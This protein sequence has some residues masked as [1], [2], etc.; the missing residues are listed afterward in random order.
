[1]TE[2]LDFDNPRI[3]A[4]DLFLVDKYGNPGEGSPYLERSEVGPLLA[5]SLALNQGASAEVRIW[6]VQKDPWQFYSASGGLLFTVEN[7]RLSLIR[8]DD[9]G[10]AARCNM[11]LRFDWTTH[12]EMADTL[13]RQDVPILV[14]A[15][16]GDEET[17]ITWNAGTLIPVRGWI[18]RPVSFMQDI[19]PLLYDDIERFEWYMFLFS[20][21]LYEC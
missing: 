16:A 4:D 12:D 18:R 20:N 5:G 3:S 10:H 13:R 6:R 11:I 1:M 17:L 15:G 19:N 8:I 14:R 7:I 9:D 2:Y 21:K